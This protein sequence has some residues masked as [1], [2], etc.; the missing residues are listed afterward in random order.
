MRYFA[1]SL[2]AILVAFSGLYTSILLGGVFSPGYLI[3]YLQACES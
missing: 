3:A 2:L 1:F